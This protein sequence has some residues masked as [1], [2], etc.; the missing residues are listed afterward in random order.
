MNQPF[1]DRLSK[2]AVAPDCML[3]IFGA[4]G[5]LTQRLLM[6]AL[7]NL[8]S[9]GLLARRFS[10]VGIGH[11]PRSDEEFRG[12]IAEALRARVKNAKAEIDDNTLNELMNSLTYIASEFDDP[13]TYE[14]VAERLAAW[15]KEGGGVGNAI[16]YLA[17]APNY[18]GDIIERLGAAGLLQ[19]G[20]NG[21]RRVVIEKPF[22]HDLASARALNRRVL[23]IADESQIYRIDHFLGKETVQNI[24]VLRFANFMFEPIWNRQHIDHVQITA[25]ETVGVEQRGRFYDETGALR[26]MVPNHMFQL[27]AMMTMEAPNS[28]H[29]D[30]IRA[31]KAKVIEAIRRLSPEDALKNVVRGQYVAGF[32][33]GEKVAAYRDAHNVDPRSLTETYIALKLW[34]DNWRWMDVPFYIRTGKAMSLRRTEIVIQFK[35]APGVLFR[36]I[37]DSKL[38]SCRLIFH[39]QPEEGITLQ[40]AA[41]QPG[42]KVQFADVNMDFR[43]AD[44]FKTSPSTGYETLIYD[45]LV[46][47]A[48]LFQRADNVEAGWAGVQPI[49][50]A[51]AI[52]P[53]DLH[54]YPAGSNGPA[55]ADMLLLR[56]GREWLSLQ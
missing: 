10:I 40:F 25:A 28:F 6:P 48:T 29:A 3:V 9:E 22:G 18:F 42:R 46:G 12:S 16:F 21:W 2:T 33:G 34:I 11:H 38:S 37:D 47:D 49:L 4:S 45:C 31:E 15:S 27:L 52:K 36:D 26:D 53:G 14:H 39:I 19:E 13:K 5:D 54:L 20:D 35:K 8:A 41:K 7:Y 51:W 50:D 1:F 43:Y 55:A 24:M 23:Q 56:D 17:T 30:A 44:Y 32:I